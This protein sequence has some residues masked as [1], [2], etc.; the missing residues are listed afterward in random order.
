MHRRGSALPILRPM[1]T[2]ICVLGPGRSGTSLTVRLLGLAGVD[3]GPEEELLTK[4][5]VPA[6]PRGFWESPRFNRLNER[7]LD[8]FGGSWDAP[9]R[10]DPGWELSAHLAPERDEARS[11]LK[12]SFGQSELWCWKDPRSSITLPFWRGLL[13]QLGCELRCV[14]CLRNPVDLVAS[15][16]AVSMPPLRSLAIWRTYLAAALLNT[17]DLPRILITY[18]RYFDDWQETVARLVGFAGCEVPEAG[19]E[20][21][22]RMRE[23]TDESLWRNRTSASEVLAS[24]DLPAGVRSLHLIAELL[25]VA[26]P[27]PALAAAIEVHARRMLDEPGEL[28]EDGGEALPLPDAGR[29]LDSPLT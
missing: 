23:F 11:L 25:A 16:E 21:E 17:A 6:N 28:E 9:P 13:Q 27:A 2:A 12:Q 7:I 18:E 22:R 5:G 1:A 24:P 4:G 15:L 20:V 19:G 14:V 29:A 3:M 8:A 10:L 26:D